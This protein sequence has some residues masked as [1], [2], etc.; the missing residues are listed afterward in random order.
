MVAPLGDYV[1]V[2]MSSKDIETASGK[3]GAV[4]LCVQHILNK[5]HIKE[6]KKQGTW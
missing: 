1:I 2:S 4:T 3:D 5:D 6:F